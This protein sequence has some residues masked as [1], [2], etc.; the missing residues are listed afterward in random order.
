MYVWLSPCELLTN[1]VFSSYFVLTSHSMLIPFHHSGRI[2]PLNSFHRSTAYHVSKNPNR[3]FFMKLKTNFI[4]GYFC[5]RRNRSLY[6][7]GKCRPTIET[8][9]VVGDDWLVKLH[10]MPNYLVCVRQWIA[11]CEF[12]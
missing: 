5:Y 10:G 7:K 3:K 12:F 4:G 8:R 11:Y 1:A 6:V 9:K 2:S